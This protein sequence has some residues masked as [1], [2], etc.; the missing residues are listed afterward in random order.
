MLPFKQPHPGQGS[1]IQEVH[2]YNSAGKEVNFNELDELGEWKITQQQG[3]LR[4]I[5]RKVP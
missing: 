2:L 4:P 1:E 5:Q 3:D